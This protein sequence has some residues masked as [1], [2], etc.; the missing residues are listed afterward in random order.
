M[1]EEAFHLVHG[2]G[3]CADQCSYSLLLDV[4]E[5]VPFARFK[6]NLIADLAKLSGRQIPPEFRLLVAKRGQKPTARATEEKR[7]EG[8]EHLIDYDGADKVCAVQLAEKAKAF[9]LLLRWVS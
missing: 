9:Q 7:F 8:V 6:D 4:V 3:N 1:A 2:T 5:K